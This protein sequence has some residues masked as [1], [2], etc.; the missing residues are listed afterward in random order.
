MH[1]S[2]ARDAM[3]VGI[4]IRAMYVKQNT[5]ILDLAFTFSKILRNLVNLFCCLRV[6]R[7]DG[8]IPVAIVL[9]TSL[10]KGEM[11]WNHTS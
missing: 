11:G 9:C 3:M 4:L 7:E 8:V 10:L 1:V 6:L 2:D 5:F